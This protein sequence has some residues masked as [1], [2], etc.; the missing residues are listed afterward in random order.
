MTV[1]KLAAGAVALLLYGVRTG[2][3]M[4]DKLAE[5]ILD[6]HAVAG[7]D[8]QQLADRWIADGGPD[9]EQIYCLEHLLQARLTDEPQWRA[10]VERVVSR[11]QVAVLALK[12]LAEHSIGNGFR[13][14]YEWC[15][16]ALAVPVVHG[17]VA[18]AQLNRTVTTPS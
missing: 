3:E 13:G 7:P 14:A 16:T 9:G 17:Q 15:L 18:P 5:A 10:A 12:A 11:D 2:R 8:L 1:T 4:N 6:L